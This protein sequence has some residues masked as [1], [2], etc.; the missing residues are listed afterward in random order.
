[1]RAFLVVLTACASST[2][3]GDAELVAF[4]SNTHL[5]HLAHDVVVL[6]DAIEVLGSWDGDRCETRVVPGHGGQPA[7]TTGPG[8][9]TA[10]EG[11]DEGWNP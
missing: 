11:H 1:M 4:P 10:G 7:G 9:G 5:S 8:P 6:G 3:I 2:T